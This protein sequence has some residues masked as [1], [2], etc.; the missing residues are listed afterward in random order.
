M[1]P[2]A[3][4]RRGE[5]VTGI[6]RWG[7]IPDILRSPRL[8]LK[9]P[10]TQPYGWPAPVVNRFTSTAVVGGKRYVMST[11]ALHEIDDNSKLVHSWFSRA[12]TLAGSRKPFALWQNRVVTPGDFPTARPQSGN[13]SDQA[14]ITESKGHLFLIGP[15]DGI[16]C[17]EPISDTWFGPLSPRH[18][19]APECLLGTAGGVWAGSEG[20]CG[21]FR[22]ED[23]IKAAQEAGR[24][25]TT[26]QVRLRKWKLAKAA[27]PLAAA[28]FDVTLRNFE[29]ARRRI[30]AVLAGS[31]D[32]PQ[33]LLLMAVM[34][35]WCLNRPDE[36]IAWY[37]RLAALKSDLSAV[38]TGLYGEFKI[39]YALSHW[40]QAIETG[41]RL[42]DEVPCLGGRD[43]AIGGSAATV[44]SSIITARQKR[45][46][47][48]EKNKQ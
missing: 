14:F 48:P 11:D 28:R 39:H 7:L 33:A 10:R 18:G 47:H 12:S 9:W 17:Y 43:V 24:V 2:I 44:E 41:E 30:E 26:E 13:V 1:A 32:D 35:D 38:Y 45:D 21:Y 31:P 34:N 4:W 22:T 15:I 8:D 16:V 36:A 40:D 27:G 25:M 6:T 29:S 23:F 46:R 42:L 5:Q 37:R 3:L 20:S 19:F